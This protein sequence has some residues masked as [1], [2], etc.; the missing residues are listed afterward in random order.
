MSNEIKDKIIVNTSDNANS[1]TP[2]AANED[3]DSTKEGK[4]KVDFTNFLS[5]AH[6]PVT[7]FFTLFFKIMAALM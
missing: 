3:T 5:H 4:E 7:V 1:K 2:K 6:H